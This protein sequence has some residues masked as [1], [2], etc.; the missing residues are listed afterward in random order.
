MVSAVEQRPKAFRE[1]AFDEVRG[2]VDR[3]KPDVEIDVMHFDIA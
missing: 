2:P 3:S 1:F